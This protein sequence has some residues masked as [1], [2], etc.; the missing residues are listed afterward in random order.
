MTLS[1]ITST[2]LSRATLPTILSFKPTITSLPSIMA[3]TVM[4]FSVPQ[5]VSL[6]ITSWATSTNLLVKYPE[7][8]VFNAVSASPLRAPWVEMKYSST[9]RPSR[10][11]AVIGFSI[12][13]PD[14]LAINPRIP[15]SCLICCRDPRAPESAIIKIG[16]NGSSILNISLESRSVVRVQISTI[17]LYL[18]LFVIKPLRYW[19]SIL[20]TSFLA[21]FMYSAFCGGTRKPLIEID[22]PDLVASSNPI[23]FNLSR[24]EITAEWP[25]CL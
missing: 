21:S 18:S 7:S 5:S 20:T 17:L 12:I 15:Q 23:S 13:S 14:G 25:N 22:M 4:P 8:A 19:S 11:L 2:T 24:I 1:V 9:V 3:S 16:L 10:K 6:T